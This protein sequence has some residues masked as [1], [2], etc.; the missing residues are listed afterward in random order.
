L[1]DRS[2]PRRALEAFGFRLLLAIVRPLP[3]GA[4]AWIASLLGRFAFD[5][6]RIRRTVAVENVLAR[7]EPAGGRAEAERI[8]RESYEV[9]AR[10]FVD[11]LRFDR[12]GE[13]TLW[14]ALSAGEVRELV[15]SLENGSGVLA[16]A[17]FGNWELLLLGLAR[18]GVVVH[19][20]ARDQSNAAADRGIKAARAKAG[21]RTLSSR[22]GLREAVRALRRGESVTSLLDQDAGGKGLFVDFLGAKASCHSGM[23]ALA[24]RTGKPMV[25][26]V[27]VDERGTYRVAL[28]GVWRP[29]PALSEEA[30]VHAGV[31]HFH[32]FLEQQ[33]RAHPGN[34][35]WAHRRWKTRPPGGEPG[36]AR[37]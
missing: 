3:R 36:E 12:I 5:V 1:A 13:R 24:A 4:A 9:M 10:T 27:L 32:R 21:V 22:T 2:R 33:V 26:V 6:V 17:H 8:A 35:F 31:Q 14:R 15:S 23:V 37:A 7:L 16:S 29:D 30:N 19:A 34:Y 20:I 18:C 28:G 11:L 25:P